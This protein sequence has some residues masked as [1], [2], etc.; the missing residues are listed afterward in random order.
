L[1]PWILPLILSG[2]II[3]WQYTKLREVIE[4]KSLAFKSSRLSLPSDAV[5][6]LINSATKV[7]T[8]IPESHES[9][10]HSP[11]KTIAGL[12]IS[13][14]INVV[15]EGEMSTRAHILVAQNL[16]SLFELS[17]RAT[18]HRHCFCLGEGGG[19]SDTGAEVWFSVTIWRGIL[20]KLCAVLYQR[21][22]DEFDVLLEMRDPKR[23]YFSNDL[24]QMNHP[25][26]I[27]GSNIYVEAKWSGSG[28][29]DF[30][31]DIISHF[32]D[33]ESDLKI[34]E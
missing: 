33:D 11:K 26:L 25:I 28:I 20:I 12:C 10:H 23:Q 27:P 9:W 13:T 3:G 14:G 22:Q 1:S 29:V 21:H 30:C 8:L 34:E 15:K 17:P 6:F 24:T 31:Q 16:K 32:G 19:S 18:I 5:T 7:I 4:V 2:I